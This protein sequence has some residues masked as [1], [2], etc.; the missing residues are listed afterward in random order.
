MC[1]YLGSTNNILQ[2]IVFKQPQTY[3]MWFEYNFWFSFFVKFST[4]T[5]KLVAEA[6][7][8]TT[9]AYFICPSFKCPMITILVYRKDTEP[10]YHL[11]LYSLTLLS[12]IYPLLAMHS[13]LVT[14]RRKKYVLKLKK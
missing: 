9:R 1:C 12:G 11:F 8:K 5:F 10:L 4:A 13:M 14:F 2:V 7:A 6:T 3:L